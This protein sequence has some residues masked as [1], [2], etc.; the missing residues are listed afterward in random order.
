MDAIIASLQENPLYLGVLIGMGALLLVSLAK[1]LI[2]LTLITAIA[3]AGM[4]YFVHTQAPEQSGLDKLKQAL[5]DNV[6]S[7]LRDRIRET[8][9]DVAEGIAEKSKDVAGD[10]AEK[11]K[12]VAEDLADRIADAA[13]DSARE[14]LEAAADKAKNSLKAGAEKAGDTVR[15]LTT[16]VR[17]KMDQEK[18]E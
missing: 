6:P 2:Q 9:K 10:L 5:E 4:F 13:N 14:E 7:E 18:A 16:K 12:D 3:L 11:S 15:E 8:S 17:E 1:K